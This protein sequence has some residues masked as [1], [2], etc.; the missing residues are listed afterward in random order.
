MFQ[1]MYMYCISISVEQ[2]VTIETMLERG[3]TFQKCVQQQGFLLL[4]PL[5]VVKGLA[6]MIFS[7]ERALALFF[8]LRSESK[9]LILGWLFCQNLSALR[10]KICLMLMQQFLRP[11][12][13]VAALRWGQHADRRQQA[14]H[15]I[16]KGSCCT[17]FG[18]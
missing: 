1:Q 15:L 8:N 12:M 9:C 7:Y 18:L 4:H 5:L 10:E 13:N 6:L 16:T 11:L 3:G 2:I 14:Q 17:S